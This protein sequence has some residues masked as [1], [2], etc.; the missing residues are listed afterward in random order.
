MLTLM[1]AAGWTDVDYP[2][3]A[4]ESG[5]GLSFGYKRCH[6]IAM[7]GLQGDAPERLAHAAGFELEWATHEDLDQAWTWVKEALDRGQPVGADYW[8][9]HLI[10]GYR[11]GDG[12]EDRQWFVLA[13]EPICAWDGAWLTWKQ[14]VK[15]DQEC[16]WSK[17]RCRSAELTSKR[18][19]GR[20]AAWSPEETVRHV[21]EWI[22]TWSER[23]PAADKGAYQGS[24]FGFEA[25]AAYAADVGD[26]SKTVE[27]DFTFGL[28][29]CHAITPQWGTRRYIGTYLADRAALFEG[30]V[31][32]RIQDAAARYHDAHAAWVA[33]DEQL[34]QRFVHKHGGDQD[35]GWADP[36]RR[37]KGSAAVYAALEHEKA[38]V[39]LLCQ[40]LSALG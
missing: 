29:A 20:T 5:V 9:W 4:V 6:C 26:L 24:F 36:V 27:T 15:L 28:N 33:F 37:S 18:Y 13:N 35:E 17:H 30:T 8:E 2:T 31:R 39:D 1:H 7:Y 22:V 21:M 16:P 19:A 32:E 40:A 25:I 12:P 34:G 14:I 38:A 10:A 3:L 11:D 23:H